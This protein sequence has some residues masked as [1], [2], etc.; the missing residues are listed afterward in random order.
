MDIRSIINEVSRNALLMN[1]SLSAS[2]ELA[3][4]RQASKTLATREAHLK[5]QV[6]GDRENRVGS[7]YYVSVTERAGS[8]SW[9]KVAD[10]L[11]KK[12]HVTDSSWTDSDLEALK[13]KHTGK[14]SKVVGVDK[15]PNLDLIIEALEGGFVVIDFETTRTQ[16]RPRSTGQHR[17]RFHRRAR[18]SGH[19]L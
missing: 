17:P 15:L 8:V 12:F 14:P 11:H 9:A 2:D 19:I 18:R 13:V 3:L 1:N 10:E 16:H 5:Q 7:E 4:V 6:L